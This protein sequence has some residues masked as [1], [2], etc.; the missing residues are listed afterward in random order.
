MFEID[1]NKLVGEI[2]GMITD[3]RPPDTVTVNELMEQAKAK[4]IS[5]SR[6]S[7]R[8]RMEKLAKGGE[9][10]KIVIRNSVYYRM[11]NQQ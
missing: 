9:I 8:T 1:H 5:I 6:E 4:G 2:L 11:R 3:E 10:E 7:I